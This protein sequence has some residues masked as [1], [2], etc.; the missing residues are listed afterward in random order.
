MTERTG[1][2]STTIS[3]RLNMVRAYD[4]LNAP[5]P[6]DWQSMGEDERIMLVTAYHRDA[7]VELPNERVHA[8]V[9]VIVENQ[10]A[11]G[12]EMLV[13]ATLKRLV[14]E[15]LDRHEALHAVASVLVDF[16]QALVRDDGAPGANERY[17]EELEKLTAAEWLKTVP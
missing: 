5:D 14:R 11:L 12:D 3:G 7:G 2:A 1:K 15:G 16:L 17:N 8:A 13:Q 6:D 4:P 10:I 9:H